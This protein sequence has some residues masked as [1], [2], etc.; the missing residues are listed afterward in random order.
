MQVS[1]PHSYRQLYLPHWCSLHHNLQLLLHAL[2]ATAKLT[3][4]TA[5]I[6]PR[7]TPSALCLST[8]AITYPYSCASP[9]AK[10]LAAP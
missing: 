3:Q 6:L 7:H 9:F 5:Q 2:H 1:P 4:G 10:D 8:Q